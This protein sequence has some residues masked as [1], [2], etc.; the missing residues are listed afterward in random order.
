MEMEIASIVIGPNWHFS[1]SLRTNDYWP[2]DID[3]EQL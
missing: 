1:G 3:G 2:Q